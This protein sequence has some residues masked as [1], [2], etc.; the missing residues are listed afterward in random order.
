[1]SVLKCLCI[2]VNV[3]VLL[4]DIDDIVIV[5]TGVIVILCV[6]R[7]RVFLHSQTSF[8]RASLIRMSHNPDTVVTSSIIFYL[9]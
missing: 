4:G 3:S 7:G 6:W 2:Y 1:M 9:Q 5:C 8:I